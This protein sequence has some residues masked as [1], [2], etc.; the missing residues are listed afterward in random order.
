M[1]NISTYNNIF[2]S[3]SLF[4][5]KVILKMGIIMITTLLNHRKLRIHANIELTRQM[6]KL[7]PA[8]SQISAYNNVTA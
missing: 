2:V 7:I 5:L 1:L 4:T 6:L 3:I 8:L